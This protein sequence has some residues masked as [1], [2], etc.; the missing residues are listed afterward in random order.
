VCLYANFQF[1][2]WSWDYFSATFRVYIYKYNTTLKDALANNT[3]H[4]EKKLRLRDR[5]DR[6]WFSRLLRHPARKQGGSILSTPEP[7]RGSN[8]CLA[9][10]LL[11]SN[12]LPLRSVGNA[13]ANCQVGI[14]KSTCTPA[15]WTRASEAGGMQGIWHPQLFMWRGYWY[16]YPPEKPKY[17][18]MQTVCN[19]Y[20]DAGKGNLAAQNTRKPFGG[21]GSAPD[22]AKGEYSAPANP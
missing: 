9:L 1:S 4:S 19:T 18:A 3:T 16:V 2:W 15:L 7:A 14:S 20:W 10:T 13:I 21:R 22:P 6:A 8:V 11:I 5:T 12:Q 17:L